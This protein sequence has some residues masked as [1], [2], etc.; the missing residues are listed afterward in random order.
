MAL[1][2]IKDAFSELFSKIWKYLLLTVAFMVLL[3]PSYFFK[4]N[5][6]LLFCLSI[7]VSVAVFFS[8]YSIYLDRYNIP[9]NLLS[10]IAFLIIQSVISYFVS[11]GGGFLIGYYL[12]FLGETVVFIISLVWS[13]LTMLLTIPFGYALFKAFKYELSLKESFGS[14]VDFYRHGFWKKILLYVRVILVIIMVTILFLVIMLLLGLLCE[15]FPPMVFI[16]FI[17]LIAFYILFIPF[18]MITICAYYEECELY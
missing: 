14:F 8:V 6:V 4:D 3:V 16:L 11:Y 17:P 2:I 5:F 18:I 15:I 9:K 13:A 1:L 10:L 7:I 12:Y